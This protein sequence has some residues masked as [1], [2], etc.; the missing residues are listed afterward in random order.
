LLALSDAKSSAGDTLYAAGITM[1]GL[2]VRGEPRQAIAIKQE[3]TGKLLPNVP[4]PFE[5]LWM[6][7]IARGGLSADQSRPASG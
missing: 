1:L 7:A 4:L 5:I 6:E 3:L 2:L